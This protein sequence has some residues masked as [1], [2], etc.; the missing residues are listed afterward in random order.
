MSIPGGTSRKNSRS[1][2]VSKG[3]S[4]SKRKGSD[5]QTHDKSRSSSGHPAI[6]SGA[7]DSNSLSCLYPS[8][9]SGISS[10]SFSPPAEPS[11]LNTTSESVGLGP[12]LKLKLSAQPCNRE[13]QITSVCSDAHFRN[14][15]NASSGFILFAP[16]LLMPLARFLSALA[17][18][19]CKARD[20][21]RVRRFIASSPRFRNPDALS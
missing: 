13:K 1:L 15:S 5:T 3:S 21:R 2:S 4:G 17:D 11:A 20:R 19:Q 12:T 16:E 18:D 14:K 6:A 7:V 10:C 9:M 8:T